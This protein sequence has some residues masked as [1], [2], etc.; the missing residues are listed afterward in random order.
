MITLK[1]TVTGGTLNSFGAD[2]TISVDGL[3]NGGALL[4]G[5]RYVIAPAG[6]KVTGS[7]PTP[8]TV[9]GRDGHGIQKNLEQGTLDP[10][11]ALDASCPGYSAGASLDLDEVHRP[12][13]C[14]VKVE[15]TDTTA[16]LAGRFAETTVLHVLAGPPQ[17]NVFTPVVWNSDDLANRP[18]R[19]VDV[20][21]LLSDLPVFAS[22]GAP[23]WAS[24]AQWWDRLDFSEALAKSYQY[25]LFSP[26]KVTGASSDYGQYRAV[27]E[28]TI[29]AGIFGN[30][31]STSDKT[32]AIIRALSNGCQIVETYT[33]NGTEIEP[34]G[35]HHQ[36]GQACAALWCKGTNQIAT[37]PTILA[38]IGGNL[39]GQYYRVT[40]GQFDPHEDAAKPYFCRLRTVAT[41]TGSGPYTIDFERFTGTGDPPSNMQFVDLRLMR[42]GGNAGGVI[43]S[44]TDLGTALRV[45]VP[46][47]PSGLIAGDRIYA[48][49]VTPLAVGTAEWVIRDTTMNLANPAPNAIYRLLNHHGNQIAPISAMGM[50]PAL[51]DMPTE[52]IQRITAQYA[53]GELQSSVLGSVNTFGQ[54]FWSAHLATVLALPQD[55]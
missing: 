28:G 29:W 22:S 50:R 25:T 8:G 42:E 3:Y 6:I 5:Q 41:I 48:A 21:A 18:W 27:I 24:L 44:F 33:G 54:T 12:G 10:V 23:T 16:S 2:A 32:A 47:L 51:L 55:V 30:E 9:G 36:F 38:A 37:W 1:P 49:E 53:F 20:D 15:S 39:T 46:T 11:Q 4:D 31:W 17:A 40:S 52:Y 14:V 34:D 26:Y 7:S 13:D 35:G 19:A 45:V 43:S